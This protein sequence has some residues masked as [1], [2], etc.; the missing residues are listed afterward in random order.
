MIID[1]LVGFFEDSF[2]TNWQKPAL[3]DYTSGKTMSYADLAYQIE[4]L[5]LLFKKSGANPGDKIALTGKNSSAWAS[6]FMASLTYGTV[7]V[8]M[9]DEFSSSDMEHIINHSDSKLLFADLSIWN[10][11]NAEELS[12]LNNVFSLKDFENIYT[13]K[14]SRYSSIKEAETLLKRRYDRT[15]CRS[16]INYTRRNNS[17]MVMISYTSGT[18][19]FTKGVMI[20]GENLAGN[21]TF[22]INRYTK[23]KVNLERS[24]CVLPLA[25]TFALATNLLYPLV[26]GSSI[27]F[28]GKTPTPQVLIKACQEVRPT[29]LFMVPLVFE[30][31][32]RSRIKSQIEKP[33]TK[34]AL[35]IPF[36]G[37]YIYHSIGNKLK[38]MFG[39]NLVEVILGGAAFNAEVEQFMKKSG[40]P[41]TVGYGMTECA[42]LI[43]C[44]FHSEHVLG[45]TG[46]V[47]PGIMEAK[48]DSERNSENVGEILVRGYN[49]MSGYYKNPEDTAKCFTPDGW[50]KTGDLG[51]IDR[52]GNIFIKGRS[53]TMF[54]SSNGENIYPEIIESKL[55]NME[56]VE[57]CL[58]I[59]EGNKLSALVYPKLEE[60]KKLELCQ[61]KLMAI[62]EEYRQ[63]LNSMVAKYERV[64]EIKIMLQEFPKTP[65]KTI[66]RWVAVAA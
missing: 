31:I 24:L 35:K 16:D 22:G 32:Y 45:S 58:V 14:N 27:T 34:L 49:V 52:K 3:I 59:Q 38:E 57:E 66:K 11:L 8:P 43:S 41:Y 39:G 36:L 60:V 13:N 62:M 2:K 23:Y 50:L 61:E 17:E 65:K 56:L 5:H 20:S 25:H 46:K 48:I 28:L 4:I 18:T 6:V 54:L 29:L 21:I 30:K 19:S 26:V 40:F 42:P 10:R 9:L 47:L 37:K 55:D 1:N 12:G 7:I 64:A 15:M 53:K 63:K 33:L 44:S 51:I